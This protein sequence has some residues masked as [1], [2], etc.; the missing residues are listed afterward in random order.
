MTQPNC[1]PRYLI[2]RVFIFF[3]F[4]DFLV[5]QLPT[6]H[7]KALHIFIFC[8][9]GIITD[10]LGKSSF[11]FYFQISTLSNLL[12]VGFVY[13]LFDKLAGANSAHVGLQNSRFGK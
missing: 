12:S 3:D 10:I 7:T 9:L 5:Q 13:T 8:V 4:A 11:Y 2:T 6:V 1:G